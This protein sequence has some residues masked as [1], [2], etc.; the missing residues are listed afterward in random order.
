MRLRFCYHQKQS[1]N[2]PHDHFL[3]NHCQIESKHEI[4]QVA[5]Y[6]KLSLKLSIMKYFYVMDISYNTL[7]RGLV[8]QSVSQIFIFNTS[9]VTEESYL[10]ENAFPNNAK[11]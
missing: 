2:C 7:Y 8:L 6:N 10:A 1:C 3:P 9:T 4:N 11:S 5:N